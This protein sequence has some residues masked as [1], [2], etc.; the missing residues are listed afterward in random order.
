M[1]SSSKPLAVVTGGASGIGLACARALSAAGWPVALLDA[2]AVAVERSAAQIGARARVVDVADAAAVEAA[3]REIEA[4]LGPVGALVT[5][6]GVVQ[7][8]LP[9]EELSID[10]YDRVIAVNQRGV[11]VTCVAFGRRMA[12]RGAG[13]IVNIASVTARRSVPLHAYAPAKAAVVATTECLAAEWGRSGV[14]VNTVSPGYTLTDRVAAQIAA[15]ERD[16]R[17]ICRNSAMPRL[18][19]PE[20]IAEAVAFLLSERASAITGVDLPVDCGWLLA[21]AWDTYGGVRA[22]RRVEPAGATAPQVTG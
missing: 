5:S 1:P 20:E 7:H 9:P 16:P 19:R 22:A 11:Y 14:R 2:N 13:A 4:T 6:A 12:Q 3:A 21:P 8:P 15:G 17:A 10:A 18:V